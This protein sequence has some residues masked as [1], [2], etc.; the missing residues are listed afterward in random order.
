MEYDLVIIGGGACGIKCALD[1]KNLGINNIILIENEKRLGGALNDII[2]AEDS[3][4]ENGLTGV[5]LSE[6][7]THEI[8][9]SNIKF[10]TNTRV[11]SIEKDKSITTINPNNGIETISAKAIIIATGASERPRGILNITSKISSGVFSIG[12]ARRFIVKEGYLP[13]RKIVIYGSD[14]TGLYLARLLVIEGAKEVTIV[15]QSKELKFP[16]EILKESFKTLGIKTLLGYTL[17]N[18]NGRNRIEGI[19][20]EKTSNIE[21]DKIKHLECDAL[22]LS[23]GLS[24]QKSLIKKFRREQEEVGVFLSG[25]AKNVTFNMNEIF[26]SAKETV[27]KVQNYLNE[28]KSN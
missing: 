28:N 26:L 17:H 25:N 11:L 8:E 18:I 12:T 10:L 27:L 6:D 21:D 3:F 7:L 13:G 16:D 19:T 9:N 24:S 22:L 23:V 20:I 14:Y 15:D 4:G 1:A 2:E 5:E